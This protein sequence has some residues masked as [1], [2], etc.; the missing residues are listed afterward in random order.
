M[1]YRQWLQ[2]RA[3]KGDSDAQYALKFQG[4]DGGINGNWVMLENNAK[5]NPSQQ[6]SEYLINKGSAMRRLHS[7]FTQ[8]GAGRA[9]VDSTGDV[10]GGGY[11]APAKVLD[12]AQ[13]NSLDS[14]IES[15][16]TIK[17]RAVKKAGVKRDTSL[18]EKKE[19][20]GREEG[21]YKGKKLSVLQDFAGAKTDTDL[22]T[23]NTL[24]N[25]I[26][27]L[28]TLG[29]GGSR[30]LTRQLLDAA[31]I[32]N[33]KANAT[34]AT[35]NRDLDSSWNEYDAGYK[36]D[37]DKIQDQFDYDEGEAVRR[38][39][40]EKQNA[41]YKKADVYNAADRRAERDEI[42]KEGNALNSRIAAADFI[43]PRYTGK[44]RA[45]ATPELA[46]YTQDIATYDTTGIAD[47][48]AAPLTPV[49]SDGLNAPGNLAVRAIAVN[50][51]DLGIK[52]K[53]ENEL[54]YGV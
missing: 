13:L 11:S 54:G 15:L 10:G 45:M 39:L 6:Y 16:A 25:L 4:D 32:S 19:E 31:N 34:Q 23:R 28:S 30:A 33:R 38:F 5:K 12:T 9:S 18:S 37:V 7:E 27:S 29:L 2:E 40:Q 22:N 51:K 43:N 49:T 20:R 36:S 47:A 42:M 44:R 17:E 21:K 8:S 41:L 50:D 48:N 14:L 46:D 52:K 26:S 24:E 35:N 3:N 53:S 1:T